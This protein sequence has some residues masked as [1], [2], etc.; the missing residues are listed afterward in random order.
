MV[1]DIKTHRL[2]IENHELKD[3]VNAVLKSNLFEKI[4]NK[5]FIVTHVA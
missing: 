2:Q 1:P 3:L 5:Y 4:L